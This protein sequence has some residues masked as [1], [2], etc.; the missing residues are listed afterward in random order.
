M[1]AVLINL[2]AIAFGVIVGLVLGRFMYQE[3]PWSAS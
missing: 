2:G 1:D 3:P